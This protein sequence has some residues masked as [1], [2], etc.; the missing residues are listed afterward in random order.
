[1]AWLGALAF[2]VVVAGGPAEDQRKQYEADI[3][4][5]ILELQQ[6]RQSNSAPIKSGSGREGVATLINLN[7]TID[8]WYLLRIAW[9]DGA[10][11]PACASRKP[12]AA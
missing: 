7:P 12:E 10:A 3:P 5:T 2:A 8:T 11:E 1:M 9:K 4:K 6:F